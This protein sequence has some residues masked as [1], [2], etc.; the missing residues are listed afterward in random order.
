MYIPTRLNDELFS[1]FI[2]LSLE[3]Q[4]AQKNGQPNNLLDFYSMVLRNVNQIL[5]SLYI[6]DHTELHTVLSNDIYR[7]PNEEPRLCELDEYLIAELCNKVGIEEEEIDIHLAELRE[8][9]N[10]KGR[11]KDVSMAGH[12]VDGIIQN[13][14]VKVICQAMTSPLIPKHLL[15]VAEKHGN[16]NVVHFSDHKKIGKAIFRS[17]RT[18]FVLGWMG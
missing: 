13:V 1:H 8:C 16:I 5:P 2:N 6:W 10:S 14:Y 18:L 7:N 4:K 11:S 17:K 12:V 15:D 9:K 3:S